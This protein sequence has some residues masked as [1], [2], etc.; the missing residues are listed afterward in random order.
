MKYLLL[1]HLENGCES[2]YADDPDKLKEYA[3]LKKF[4]YFE[5]YELAKTIYSYVAAE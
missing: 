1:V 2:Y 5:I 3:E 4:S